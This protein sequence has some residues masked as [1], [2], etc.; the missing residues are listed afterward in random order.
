MHVNIASKGLGLDFINP[1]LL[2]ICPVPGRWRLEL[3]H[4]KEERY[5]FGEMEIR[6]GSLIHSAQRPLPLPLR[7]G[8]SL[9][10]LQLKE[11]VV[12]K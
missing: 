4:N 2:L 7:R 3:T 10:M 1:F 8:V 6:K 11:W 9:P 12:L 5:P